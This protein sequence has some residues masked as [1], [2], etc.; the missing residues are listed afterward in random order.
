M[1]EVVVACPV[2]ELALGP[3]RED[4]LEIYQ[5]DPVEELFHVL[6]LS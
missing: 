3:D 2:D 5:L 6:A 1:D 4:L